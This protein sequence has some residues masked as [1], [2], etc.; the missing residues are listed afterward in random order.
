MFIDQAK[1]IVKAGN[2]GNGCTSLYQD[3]FNMR[4]YTDGG[5]G[6]WGA[7]VIVRSD[8]NL[9]TLMDLQFKR[10]FIGKHGGHG[11]S[12]NQRGRDALPV[13]IRVPC[14]TIIRDIGIDCLLGELDKDGQEL[15]VAHGGKGGL[16]NQKNREATPGAIGEE[17]E[18]QFDL[19]LLADVG[20]VG[21]PN[22]G[23]STLITQISN[24][25]PKIAAY[26]FTT[27]S[28]ML[29]MVGIDSE[30][31]VVA[32][33]PGLIEGSAE[34]RGLGDRFLRHVERTKLLVHIIDMAGFEGRDPIDD[35]R[36][37]NQELEGYSPIVAKKKQVV[38]AN[39]MDLSSAAQ[40]LKRFKKA[41]KVKVYPISALKAEGLEELVE[42]IRKKL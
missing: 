10:H 28:P 16:G 13:I 33:I 26:P 42:A 21:F 35:Y 8:R 31:F 41:V 5:D 25:T 19:K 36:I 37:I 23:K 39:K 11:S 30:A 12:K 24:A 17:K 38:V 27:K 2:G 15:V 29:G 20:L 4:G 22:A 3:K 6:G 14:G 32:D 1:V 18:L 7:D 40:N 9:R 34:G